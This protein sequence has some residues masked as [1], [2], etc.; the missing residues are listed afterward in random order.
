MSKKYDQSENASGSILRD[1]REESGMTRER[2]SERT[3]IGLRHLAAIELGEKNP[4][5]STLIRLV[6][7]L[8]ASADRIFYPEKYSGDSDMERISRLSATC[9]PKQRKMIITFIE[10]MLDHDEFK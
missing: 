5:V 9:S 6:R 2:V 8:G 3:E 1:I 10:M 7:G 4:S